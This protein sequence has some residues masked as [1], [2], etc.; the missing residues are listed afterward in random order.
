MVNWGVLALKLK[1]MKEMFLYCRKQARHLR[2]ILLLSVLPF[3]GYADADNSIL[4]KPTLKVLDIGNSF[5]LDAVQLLP[6]IANASGS[7]LSSICLYRCYRSGATFKN[8]YD[9]Y[10]DKDSVFTYSIAKVLGGLPST[11][12]RGTGEIGDGSL[13]RQVLT[14]E[15]WDLIIIHQAGPYAPYYGTW[16]QNGAGGYLNEL[17]A[18]IREHQPQA[19]IGFLL[20]HSYWRDYV[21]NSEKSAVLRWQKIADATQNFCEDYNVDFVIPYGTAIQNLRASSWNNEYDLTRDGLHC[22]FGLGQYT[23]ACC[24]Y[25]ALIAPRSGISIMGNTARYDATSMTSTY[26]AISVT[27]ENAIIAQE[28]AFLAVQDWYHCNNPEDYFFNLTYEV[29]GEVFKT[30]KVAYGMPLTPEDAP[31]RHG[32][33]FTGWSE[34]PQNMPAHDVTIAG[35]FVVSVG[36]N[37]IKN[38]DSVEHIYRLDGTRSTYRQKGFNIIR[39]GKTTFKIYN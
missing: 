33:T 8:W 32:Y 14:Q 6:R 9:I 23:A 19:E 26:P 10:H 1:I 25:E 11:A 5:T 37:T 29:D 28:A 18:L 3:F 22:C 12:P 17:L 38:D 4:D 24:Y 13:F 7:N 2:T 36:M 27:D 31:E 20:V 16:T 30:L 21:G 34:I 35:S 39:R 15:K